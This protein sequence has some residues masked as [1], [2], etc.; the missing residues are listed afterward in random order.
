MSQHRKPWKIFGQG[1]T[2]WIAVLAF[3]F[4][5]WLGVIGPWAAGLWKPTI[6]IEPPSKMAVVCYDYEEVVPEGASQ[7]EY[8]CTDSSTMALGADLFSFW[9]SSTVSTKQEIVKEI[10]GTFAIGQEAATLEWEYF[11]NLTDQFTDNVRRNTARFSLDRGDFRNYEI[12][13]NLGESMKWSAIREG[14]EIGA[15]AHITFVVEFQHSPSQTV[16]C[17]L[18]LAILSEQVRHYYGT[19]DQLVCEIE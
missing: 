6:D 15:V 3:L 1:I 13:F 2:D 8:V 17:R 18:E 5:L 9:N 10:S 19:T 4:S 16:S 14:I 11:T 12:Q 7:P